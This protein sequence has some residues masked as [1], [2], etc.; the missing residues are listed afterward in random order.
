MQDHTSVMLVGHIS[1]IY[2]LN[3]NFMP[4]PLKKVRGQIAVGS[5]V[6]PCP[7]KKNKVTVLKSNKWVPHQK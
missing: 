4:Q 1:A 3:I 5:S 6:R 7:F 2:M